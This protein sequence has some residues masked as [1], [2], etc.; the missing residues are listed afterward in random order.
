MVLKLKKKP[1]LLIYPKAIET[2]AERT[3]RKLVT[4]SNEGRKEK[5]LFK[6]YIYIY[7]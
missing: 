2:R 5:V 6:K 4:K 3:G 7:L 1:I